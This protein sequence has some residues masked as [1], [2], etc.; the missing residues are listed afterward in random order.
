MGVSVIPFLWT[1]H[2]SSSLHSPLISMWHIWLRAYY[3][4]QNCVVLMLVDARSL[5]TNCSTGTS[6]I[7]V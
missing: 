6:V 7:S 1:A 4:S 2:V 5:L 3:S